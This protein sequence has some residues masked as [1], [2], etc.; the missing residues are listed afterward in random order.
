MNNNKQ[1]VSWLCRL[2][3]GCAL[4]LATAVHAGTPVWTF[5]PLTATSVIVSTT[6]SAI[7]QYAVT[8]QSNKTHTL[9][10][11]PIEGIQAEGCTT[12]LG[13]HQSCTLTLS[14]TGSTLTGAVVGGPVLCESGN[15]NQCYQP[16]QGDALNIQQSGS[17]VLTSSVDSLALS[18]SGHTEY[19][20]TATS[21]SGAQ[22]SGVPRVITITNTGSLIATGLT[23]SSSNLPSGT[24][25]SSTCGSSL[26]S[27]ASCTI[28]V[29]PGTTASS[30]SSGSSCANGGTPVAGTIQISS[31]NA[32][33]KAISVLVLDYACIHQEGYIFAFDDTAAITGSVG[34]KVAATVDQNVGIV[35]DSSTN[36]SNSLECYETDADSTTNGANALGG[37]TYLIYNVLTTENSELASSYAAGLCT[38]AISG[39]SDWYLPAICEMGYGS[40]NACGSSVTPMLQNMQSNLIDID[41]VSSVASGLTGGGDNGRYWSSTEESGNPIAARIQY[42]GSGGGSHQD[43][44]DK[45]SQRGVRCVRGLTP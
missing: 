7:V 23:L 13:A 8:N 26:A 36:C 35:W 5:S 2:G 18:V 3:G 41:S 17:P 19:G 32:A 15:P 22:T 40:S 6:G 1:K 10:M 21:G 11:R 44:P 30:D 4:L 45:Y 39:Y 31:D 34:G 42:F 12:P 24:S 33:T 43:D 16:S 14:I 29:T 25:T 37:N 38:V 28:T 27:S 9:R 20:I